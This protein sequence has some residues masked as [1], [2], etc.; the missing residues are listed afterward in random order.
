MIS[1]IK[2]IR[3]NSC[4]NY[5]NLIMFNFMKVALSGYLHCFQIHPHVSDI[6]RRTLRVTSVVF[7]GKSENRFPDD[8]CQFLFWR[9]FSSPSTNFGNTWAWKALEF[10]TVVPWFIDWF[11]TK[12]RSHILGGV[13]SNRGKNRG[14]K[15]TSTSQVYSTLAGR[16]FWTFLNHTIPYPRTF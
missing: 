2:I 11:Q 16:E 9:A 1:I 12:P 3:W 10:V 5:G 8:C 15:S 14:K 6:N 7:Q 4:W 13:T